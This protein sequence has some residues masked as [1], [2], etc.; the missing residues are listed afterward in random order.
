MDKKVAYVFAEKKQ[1]YGVYF[2]VVSCEGI[3]ATPV[4]HPNHAARTIQG[5]RRQGYEII[6]SGVPIEQLVFRTDAYK[7]RQ[8]DDKDKRILFLY[9][10]EWEHIANHP[11]ISRN[12]YARLLR[13]KRNEAT[14]GVLWY[15]DADV[16]PTGSLATLRREM[17]ESFA[18][19]SGY[20]LAVDSQRTYVG[21]TGM[22]QFT[23]VLR[24]FAEIL[25]FRNSTRVAEFDSSGRPLN[26]KELE[27][28]VN[29]GIAVIKT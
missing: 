14:E 17:G 29:E 26:D 9:E 16:D 25:S 11:G 15:F 13:L 12:E 1:V 22:D 7:Y 18:P 2:I 21:R 10:R 8:L 24:Y 19:S 4:D 23:G 5:L 28:L 6:D 20:S 3:I 27:Y